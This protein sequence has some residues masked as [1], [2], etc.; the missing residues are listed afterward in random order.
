MKTG[1]PQQPLPLLTWQILSKIPDFVLLA[2]VFLFGIHWITQ[3][4]EEVASLVPEEGIH[5]DEPPTP[6]LFHLIGGWLADKRR[7]Q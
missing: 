2:G 6:G 3:R 5:A 1:M 7:K 4:R